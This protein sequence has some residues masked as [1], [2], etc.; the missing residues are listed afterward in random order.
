MTKQTRPIPQRHWQG[1]TAAI[2]SVT[3]AL[4]LSA[5]PGAHA[6]GGLLDDVTEVVGGVT[7]PVVTP[8]VEAVQ[9][10]VPQ[11]VQ[12]A[13]EPAVEHVVEPAVSQVEQAGNAVPGADRVV[14]PVVKA[15]EPVVR[16]TEPSDGGPGDGPAG[17]TSDPSSEPAADPAGAPSPAESAP[18]GDHAAATPGHGGG[19]GD[20][21][22][23]GDADDDAATGR[24]R[25]GERPSGDAEC[26]EGSGADL[27]PRAMAAQVSLGVAAGAEGTSADRGLWGVANAL[28]R[29]GVG[30]SWSLPD[31]GS[32][33]R[34]A[35]IPWFGVARSAT[36][37]VSSTGRSGTVPVLLGLLGLLGMLVAGASLA[38][39]RQ[40]DGPRRRTT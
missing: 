6:D 38:R 13:V 33:D 34:L 21:Q 9:S 19:H 27:P 17:G 2:A 24:P 16:P 26:T 10:A 35:D 8:T 40:L 11:P 5:S 12:Q 31:V 22:G 7:D 37:G 18:S 14:Q 20:A 29:M 23:N 1:R 32:S 39:S 25:D 30:G 3:L 4:S 15:V 28:M 36:S